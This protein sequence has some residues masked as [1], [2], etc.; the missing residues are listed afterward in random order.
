MELDKEILLVF[1][2][3]ASVQKM[4]R[5]IDEL[6]A[7]RRIAKRIFLSLKTLGLITPT[8]D[9]AGLR[10]SYHATRKGRAYMESVYNITMPEINQYGKVPSPVTNSA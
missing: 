5:H 6:N 1:Q 9:H 7:D 4:Y 3:D 10:E 8:N 2:V